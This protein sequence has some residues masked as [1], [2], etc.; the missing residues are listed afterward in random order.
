V[1]V[2]SRQTSCRRQPRRQLLTSPRPDPSSGVESRRVRQELAW[3]RPAR[4]R[5]IR[6]HPVRQRQTRQRQ[7]RQRQTRQHQTEQHQTRQ[8]QAEHRQPRQKR[9][10]CRVLAGPG[11]AVADSAG[12]SWTEAAGSDT[13]QADRGRVKARPVGGHAVALNARPATNGLTGSELGSSGN[14]QIARHGQKAGTANAGSGG[15]QKPERQRPKW[16]Y[17]EKAGTTNAGSGSMA[18][19]RNGKG[20][21]RRQPRRTGGSGYCRYG[22]AEHCGWRR[23]PRNW[24]HGAVVRSGP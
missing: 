24:R 14:G 13:D 19:S 10:R 21:K 22:S 15:G 6:Q 23:C 4:R 20:R 16:R 2:N 12:V 17:G 3:R 9:T 8:H 18:S 11:R 5:R 1:P 7:T